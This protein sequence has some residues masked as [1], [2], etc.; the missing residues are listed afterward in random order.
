MLRAVRLY[1]GTSGF[2]YEAWRG[3]F[4]PSDLPAAGW[5]AFYASQ[6]GAVEINN[7]FYRMPKPAVVAGWRAQVP[8]SFR[9][10]VK[11]SRRIT[12]FQKLANT[13]DSVRLLAQAIDE[14]GATRGP[15]LFQ[16]P[17]H[18]RADTPLLRAFLAGLPEGLV[19]V[20]EFQH[21]SWDED[22]TRNVLAER[23]A[24]V[25]V[26]D[27]ITEGLPPLHATGRI[28][29][30]RLRREDY[31]DAS[32]RAL[33]AALRAQPWDEAYTF[34]KHEDAGAGPRLARRFATLFTSES[35]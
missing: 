24:V 7:T 10:A 17:R 16:V 2:S 26:N 11:A 34:F 4:Y 25:C 31:D 8:E 14:L 1:T 32:L 13:G 19:P 12:H 29:Y 33:A 18:I 15:V 21:P 28:G 22:A 5:L 20:F 23:S 6:L 30:L 35:T 3:P 9:F 27:E